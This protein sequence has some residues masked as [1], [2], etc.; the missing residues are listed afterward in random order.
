VS[1]GMTFEQLRAQSQRGFRSLRFEP[2]LEAAFFQ[3][4]IQALRERARPV[5]VSA[6]ALFLV[7]CVLDYACFPER[8]WGWTIPIRLFVACP[9]ILLVLLLH[10]LEQRPRLYAGLYAFSYLWCSLSLVLIIAVARWQSVAMPY[11]GI[12][13]S[14]MFGYFVMG[15]SWRTVSAISGLIV[16]AYLGV[17]WTAGTAHAQI[18]HNSF[19]LLTAHG[20]GMVGSWLQE[21]GQRTHFLDRC[22]LD[23]GRA[24]AESDSERK[25]RFVAIASH[26]LRQPLNVINLLL[27]NLAAPLSKAERQRIQEQLGSS[28]DHLNRLLESLLDMS[29]LEEGLVHAL[30]EPVNVSDMLTRIGRES[31]LGVTDDG[32]RLDLS[33]IGKDLWARVDPILLRRILR[34]LVL[35]AQQHA[36]CSHIR[37]GAF[38]DGERVIL[39]VADDGRGIALAE[40]SV[41]FDP[42]TKGSGSVSPERGLGLGLAI[43]AQLTRLMNGRHELESS[44]GAGAC[45][46]LVF[47]RAEP[48]RQSVRQS[49]TEP[50]N[51]QSGARVWLIEPHRTSRQWLARLLERWGY[52]VHLIDRPY[53]PAGYPSVPPDLVI[54]AL[55]LD[56]D[57]EDGHRV[58]AAIREHIA[59]LPGLILTADARQSAGF[60]T[61]SRTWLLH[62]PVTASRLRT[63]VTRLLSP[64]FDP[65]SLVS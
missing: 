58:L 44:P 36:G 6:L 61:A 51:M 60:D 41:L 23:L 17:E 63:V 35:N 14:L 29:R 57:H 7:Y 15:L 43:V 20:M 53:R 46:R 10:P 9:V 52:R 27:A 18:L 30:P 33:S 59:D 39:E 31:G 2:E 45:F 12:L 25:S 50:G 11:D 21:Y 32:A 3:S 49:G 56:T 40:Q 38:G 5:A 28:V 55:N 8:V 64:G 13:L 24:R 4:R 34:N 37:L 16:I 26:D 54:T 19:F 47:P 48:C 65:E 22:Q 1:V 62:K 42:Y